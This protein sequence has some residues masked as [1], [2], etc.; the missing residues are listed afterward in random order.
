MSLLSKFRTLE[1]VLKDLNSC[2][3]AFSGGVDS[4]LL[5]HVANF[6][7]GRERVLAITAAS[8]I[9]P[10]E[11]VEEAKSLAQSIGARHLVIRTKGLDNQVF[12]TNPP[13]RCY[14]CKKE[15]YSKLWKEARRYGFVSLVDGLNADDVG[16]YRPGVKATKE[17]GVRSPLEEAGLRKH[18]IR[19]LSQHLGLPTANKPSS[20]CLATRFPYGTKITR[21]ALSQVAEAERFLRNLGIPELRVRH[22]GNLARVEVPQDFFALVIQRSC[23]IS[24]RLKEM[25]YTYVTLDIQGFRSGSMDETLELRTVS[26]K[27]RPN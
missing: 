24:R 22:H 3:V 4:T 2:V 26:Q 15:V 19:A 21:E 7:L 27:L 25:G 10:A 12:V 6:V 18:E 20:P 14:H 1:N 8:E 23:E 11:E 13:D 17:A 9:Y 5:L 16:H